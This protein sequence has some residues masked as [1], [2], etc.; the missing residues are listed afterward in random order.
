MVSEGVN[1]GY[2]DVLGCFWKRG[3]YVCARGK[4]LR[5]K[6]LDEI[7]GFCVNFCAHMEDRY[8]NSV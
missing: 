4:W 5:I 8:K 7:C 6:E 1:L 3:C 2:W